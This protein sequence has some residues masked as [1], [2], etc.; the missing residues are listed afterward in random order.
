MPFELISDKASF[1]SRDGAKLNYGIEPCDNALNFIP[2]GLLEESQVKDII[3]DTVL[4][5]DTVGLFKVDKSEFPFDLFSAAFYLV[6][7]YEEYLT[8]E[9]DKHQR[10]KAENSI[11]YKN[12]FLEKPVVNEY[13]QLL[14]ELIEQ[15]YP[16]LKFPITEFSVVPTIDID[17]AYAYKYKGLVFHIGSMVK[18]LLSLKFHLV[19][20]HLKTIFDVKN[21]PYNSYVKQE[22]VH[23]ELALKAVYFF[24]VG[25]KGK[26]DRN[27][28]LKSLG[29]RTL[30]KKINVENHVGIHPSY[31][32]NSDLKKVCFEK[33]GL[34]S[35]LGHKVL[36]SRQHFLKMQIPKTYHVL[37]K[38]GVTDDYTMGYASDIG[39]RA[40]I[41]SV[42]S[43][44]FLSEERES[45]LRVH[46]FCVMDATLKYYKNI[47]PKSTVDL[48]RPMFNSVKKVKGEIN[49]LFHN[50]SIGAKLH[51]KEW[52]GVYKEVLKEALND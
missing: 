35:V 16:E 29:L 41:S 24:L 30:I 6:T 36:K 13:A 31:G 14:K 26:Y 7:R 45:N 5:K 49:V 4:F 17:N 42:Y 18:K 51:W 48:L 10:Y 8:D 33:Q 28:S 47:S 25:P 39:F 23:K 43:F 46:P 50:E 32:S 12:G 21:D 22:S 40:S 34:E 15:R 1:I 44:Y 19:L 27:L 37:E 20:A 38:A 52:E 3:V 11:A 2:S 9:V